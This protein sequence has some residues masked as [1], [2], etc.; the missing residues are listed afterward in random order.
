MRDPSH[1]VKLFSWCIFCMVFL[2]GH[3]SLCLAG[4]A[5]PRQ[6]WLNFDQPQL[7]FS[8]AQ[9]CFLPTV[10]NV[11]HFP[12]IHGPPSVTATALQRRSIQQLLSH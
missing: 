8:S 5:L 7:Y 6:T 11:I 1:N 12:I 9:L 4:S 3:L 10:T 2:S